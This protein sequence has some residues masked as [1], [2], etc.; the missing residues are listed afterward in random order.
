MV[1]QHQWQVL[2]RA[3]CSLCETMLHELIEL[4][5]KPAANEILITEIADHPELERKY[6][7]R[8]PVLLIDGEFVCDY[9][10][11]RDR[12]KQYLS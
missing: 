7:H 5:G 3:E 6:A 1:V 11:D 12:V 9:R 10:L 4:L 2:S 8:I